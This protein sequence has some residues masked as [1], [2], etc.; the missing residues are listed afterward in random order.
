MWDATLN[1]AKHGKIPQKAA[2]LWGAD[3]ESVKLIYTGMNLVYSM[4][5]HSKIKYLCITHPLI[6]SRAELAAA[7]HYQEYLFATG[8]P[9]CPP[10]KSRRGEYLEEVSDFETTF[11]ANVNDAVQ[12]EFIHSELDQQKMF[13]TWGKSLAHLHRAAKSYHPGDA[14]QFLYWRD[15]WEEIGRFATNEDSIIKYEFA[16]IDEWLNQ[17]TQ[18]QHDFGLTLGEYRS[19]NILYDGQRVHIIDIDEPVYHWYFADVARSFLDL[20]VEKHDHWKEKAMWFLDGYYTI[21]P[22]E[23][24]NFQSLPW[25]IRMKN[26]DAYLWLKNNP[27]VNNDVFNN[28]HLGELREKIQNPL[29]TWD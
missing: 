28:I 15:L 12:G 27:A 11:L 21:A 8:A 13:E 19:G 18:N 16:A 14:H 5:C 1:K 25:F 17:L 24:S 9:V 23:D 6:R 26:L 29:L 4:K 2:E 3:K 10:V 20:N 7:I 22:Y